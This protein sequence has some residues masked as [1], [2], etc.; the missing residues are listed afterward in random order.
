[1]PDSKKPPQYGLLAGLAHPL[2]DDEHTDEP[3]C[4]GW[5]WDLRLFF[6]IAGPSS[7]FICGFQGSGKSHMLSC[8]LEYCFSIM[9]R[10]GHR[11]DLQA[12]VPRW[13]SE[14]NACSIMVP[15]QI[16][17]L[18]LTAYFGSKDAVNSLCEI[19]MGA[20]S[21]DSYGWTLL[22]RLWRRGTRLWQGCC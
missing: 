4:L 5:G 10:P 15:R 18:H 17:G 8:L 22:F 16:T 7:M 14:V 13:I 21:K 19:G 3:S 20:D 1:M 9:W 11:T 2:Y 6:N 12:W